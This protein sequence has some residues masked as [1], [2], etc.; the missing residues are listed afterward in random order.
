MVGAAKTL[1]LELLQDI[2]AGNVRL[3]ELAPDV[4]REYGNILD[5]CYQHTT[6]LS[7]RTLDALHLAPA[8]VAGDTEIVA[9][10]KR[11][12]DAAKLL[13]FSLFPA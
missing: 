6:A 2:A 13:G 10:D 8:R 5:V 4:E 7:V 12:R 11:L 9:T 1:Y 3:I